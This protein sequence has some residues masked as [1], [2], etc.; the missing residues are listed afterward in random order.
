MLF[1]SVVQNGHDEDTAACNEG[2]AESLAE[3]ATPEEPVKEKPT[4]AMV[5]EATEGIAEESK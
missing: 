2:T 1:F 5:Q 3:E 4:E